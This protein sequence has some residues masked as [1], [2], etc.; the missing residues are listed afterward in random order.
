MNRELA[1]K[2][3]SI[4]HKLIQL[5]NLW[6]YQQPLQNKIKLF[7]IE[8]STKFLKLNK[9]KIKCNQIEMINQ[10]RRLKIINNL[11]LLLK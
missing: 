9:L 10:Q 11:N 7:M 8:Y 6:I 3:N 5:C 1:I 4:N 2:I